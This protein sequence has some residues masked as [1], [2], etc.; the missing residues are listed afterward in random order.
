LIAEIKQLAEEIFPQSIEIY[1]H[2]PLDLQT[3]C[4]DTTQL[5]QVLTNLCLNARD[6]MPNGGMLMISAEN[7][8]LDEHYVRTN[9]DAHV[10]PYVVIT[11][12]DTGVGIPP[13]ILDRIFEPFF[14]TKEFGKGTGLG[15]STV[16]GIV[17]S[18]DGFIKVYSEVGRGTQFRVYLPAVETATTLLAEDLNLPMG[19]H[20]LILVVDDEASIREVIKTSL[21]TY[22]YRV[23]TARDGIEAITLYV[24]YEDEIK[25]VLADMIMPSMDGVITIRTLQKMNSDVKIIALSGL[26]SSDRVA[27]A[28]SAGAQA[29]LPKPFT[30]KELLQTL[31][32]V[33]Q[34]V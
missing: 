32:K 33:L 15:L 13:G 11:V 30:T 34:T 12:A 14:T 20:E 28:V 21:E 31:H 8:F 2:I 1:T 22:N 4:G 17:K 23:L 25:V 18:H 29:F 19:E 7:A 5:H 3:V 27:V 10:G 6:A 24:Q 16:I 26:I 9:L